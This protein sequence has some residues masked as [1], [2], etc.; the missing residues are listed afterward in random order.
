LSAVNLQ[1]RY[2]K[3]SKSIQLHHDPTT[4]KTREKT[5][6]FALTRKFNAQAFEEFHEV[7]PGDGIGD[8]PIEHVIVHLLE[9]HQRNVSEWKAKLKN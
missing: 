4:Q 8:E 1:D 6:P 2:R 7:A 5:T 9:I 3:T